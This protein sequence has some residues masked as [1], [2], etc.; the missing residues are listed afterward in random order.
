MFRSKSSEKWPFITIKRIFFFGFILTGLCISMPENWWS[1]RCRFR[2]RRTRKWCTN[3]WYFG[4]FASRIIRLDWSRRSFLSHRWKGNHQNSDL[5]ITWSSLRR[6]FIGW[7][8]SNKNI[9]SRSTMFPANRCSQLI[10][11]RIVVEPKN[12]TTKFATNISTKSS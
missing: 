1:N 4:K 11:E 8:W 6:H 9:Q 7:P 5:R 2:A 10:A 3:Q 12:I